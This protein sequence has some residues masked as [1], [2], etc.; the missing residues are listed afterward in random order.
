ML[1]HEFTNW[2]FSQDL[3]TLIIPVFQ[4]SIIGQSDLYIHQLNLYSNI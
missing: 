4:Y 2:I 3:A 1:T